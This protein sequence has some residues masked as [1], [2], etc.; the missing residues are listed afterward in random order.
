MSSQQ[1]TVRNR[2]LS[3]IVERNSLIQDSKFKIQYGRIPV[4]SSDCGSINQEAITRH[5]KKY[6]C[7][8]HF[9][10]ILQ[11]AKVYVCSQRHNTNSQR[12]APFGRYLKVPELPTVQSLCCVSYILPNHSL[13][14]QRHTRLG[15][16]QSLLSCLNPW[17][18]MKP[19][20]GN[21]ERPWKVQAFTVTSG[22]WQP[23]CKQGHKLIKRQILGKSDYFIFPHKSDSELRG[24]DKLQ[25]LNYVLCYHFTT[26]SCTF[27]QGILGS[28]AP[29]L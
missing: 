12:T 11:K 2:E 20:A 17:K 29:C 18:V 23:T 9:H 21:W 16:R 4:K 8:A 24:P 25:L 5:R 13:M 6:S 1:K 28:W 19:I 27:P 14:P 3:T 7:G 22:N 15:Y 10:R 26:G